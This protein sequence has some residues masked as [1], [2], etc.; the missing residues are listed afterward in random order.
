LGCHVSNIAIVDLAG[1][2]TACT[3]NAG[4]ADATTAVSAGRAR[5]LPFSLFLAKPR[6][7]LPAPPSLVVW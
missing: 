2:T 7:V 3:T 1:A 5:P 6:L 4:A